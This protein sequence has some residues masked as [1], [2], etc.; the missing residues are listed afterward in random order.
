MGN[1]AARVT[2]RGRTRGR[3]IA[4]VALG[5]GVLAGSALLA[6]RARSET[7]IGIFRSANDLPNTAFPP[8]WTV[9]NMGRSVQRPSPPR[10]PSPL[11]SPASPHRS[12]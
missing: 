1:A 2:R 10:W 9:C 12:P 5:L 7:E 6:R 11:G 3:N 4:G 8:I